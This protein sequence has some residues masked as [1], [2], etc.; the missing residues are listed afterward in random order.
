MREDRP[1]YRGAWL[2]M[3]GAFLTAGPGIASII[4]TMTRPRAAAAAPIATWVWLVLFAGFLQV[5]YATYVAQ[6]KHPAALRVVSA[7]CLALAALAAVCLGGLV[8]AG[9]TSWTVRYLPPVGPF[10]VSG[11]RRLGWPVAWCLL[12]VG[13]QVALSVWFAAQATEARRSR[14]VQSS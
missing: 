4:E 9:P 11:E 6:C 2:L 3:L 12:I 14:T 7:V 8:F 5:A 1:Y 13:A 10:G